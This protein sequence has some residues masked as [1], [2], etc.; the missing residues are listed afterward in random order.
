MPIRETECYKASNLK[1]TIDFYIYFCFF[2]C[3]VSIFFLS[4]HEN[5]VCGE[6]KRE[7]RKKKREGRRHTTQKYWTGKIAIVF[8]L[9]CS[10]CLPLRTPR[11]HFIYFS[12]FFHHHHHH[13][14]HGEFFFLSLSL[15]SSF[16]SSSSS[17]P[18]SPFLA[19]I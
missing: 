11:V 18:S 4:K 17:F 8:C 15:S 2:C 10:E 7:E 6:R 14:H 12:F 3:S 5:C 19:S 1:Y 16:P 9:R 13:H